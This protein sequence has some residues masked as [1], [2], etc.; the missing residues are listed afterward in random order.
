MRV[1]P[2]EREIRLWVQFVRIQCENFFLQAQAKFVICSVHF[3]ENCFT[4]SFDTT[5]RR[6]LKPGSLPSIWGRKEPSTERD[7]TRQSRTIRR[8]RSGESLSHCGFFL[9]YT[10][11]LSCTGCLI[12]YYLIYIANLNYTLFAT[13]KYKCIASIPKIRKVRDKISFSSD[14]NYLPS[15]ACRTLY[16]GSKV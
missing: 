15:H 6:Q 2:T 10:F 11:A 5:Q 8:R 13:I 7:S 9:C 1:Q 12:L 3:E 14:C 16:C 4:R